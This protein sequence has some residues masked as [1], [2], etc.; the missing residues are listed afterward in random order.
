MQPA[1]VP[2]PV[3]PVD[4]SATQPAPLGGMPPTD[5]QAQPVQSVQPTPVAPD[6]QNQATADAA[7]LPVGVDNYAV[8]TPIQPVYDQSNQSVQPLQPVQSMVPEAPVVAQP[9]LPVS[10]PYVTPS[11]IPQGN[12]L[13]LSGQPLNQ[14]VQPNQQVPY[15]LPAEPGVMQP[16]IDVQP[17]TPVASSMPGM[18]GDDMAGIPSDFGTSFNAQADDM[19]AA[20][21]AKKSKPMKLIIIGVAVLAVVLILGL[22]LVFSSRNS[23]KPAI[24]LNETPVTQPDQAK[25]SSSTTPVVIPA[26]YQKVDRDCYS[27]GVLLPTTVDFTKTACSMDAK[28]GSLSQYILTIS[29][30]TDAVVDLQNL[31]DKAKIGTITSQDDIKLGGVVAKKIIQKVNGLDQQTVVVIPTNKAYLSAG[32]SVNGF[33]INTSASD[34]ASKTASATLISTWVWK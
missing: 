27:Y 32:K 10:D 19:A 7:A 24:Q 6:W 4:L 14:P 12:T 29:P 23:R 33:I 17:T 22:V 20:Q 2:Q 31:V 26:G 3:Q 13:D 25:D 21:N 28:F 11:A 1:Q 8:N 9:G 16:G 34:D 30:V 18:P 5:L 15:T